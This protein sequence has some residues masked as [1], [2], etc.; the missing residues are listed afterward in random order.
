MSLIQ[1][2]LSPIV[3]LREREGATALSMFVFSFCM[4]ASYNAIKPV[5]RSAF[6]K[7]LGADNLPWMPLV[8]A[9]VIAFLMGGYSWMFQ[10]LPRRWNLPIVQTGMAGL[11]VLFWFLFQTQAVWVAVAFY[12]WGLLM[13][14]LLISQFWTLANIIY[15]P[16]Q[17]KRLFGFIGGGAPLGGFAGALLAREATKL[18]TYNLLFYSAA[19]LMAAVLAVS[20]ILQREKPADTGG[21]K[22]VEGE[23]GVGAGEALR[24]LR[25][26]KHLQVISLVIMFA[27]IGAQV[28]E[29]QLNMA[30]ESSKGRTDID[31]IT[32]FLATIGVWMSA[33]A[34]VIQVWLTSRIH[35]LLGI[36]FALM[37]L[38]VSLGA[39]ALVMLFNAA[40]W[41]P[42]LARVL[43][44]SLR[45]TIDKTTREIL[46]LPLPNE[47]KLRAKPFVDVT[48]DRVGKG[49]AGLLLLVMVQP[50]GLN[51]D[52]QRVS[53]ASLIMV[54][55]WVVAALRAK[56]GYLAAF[57]RSIERRDV[58]VAEVRIST[59]DLGTVETLVEELAHPDETRVLYAIDVLESLD[60]RNLVTPLLL[61]HESSAVRARALNALAVARTEIAARWLPAVERMLHDG[62]AGVRAAAVW[63]L[64]TIRGE[65]AVALARP[66]LEDRDPRIACT[67]AVVLA[68]SARGEDRATAEGALVRIAGDTRAETAGA[69]RDMAAA[70]GRLPHAELRPLLIYDPDPSVA[71]EAL[72]TVKML[73]ASDF[74]FVP[75]LVSLLRKRRLKSAA[76]EVLVSYGEPVLD[77]LNHFLRDSEEEIWVR[78]HLPATLAQFETQRAVDILTGA[79]QEPD[80]FLRYKAVAGLERL[81]RARPDLT[82]PREPI[83]ALALREGGRFLTYL[84]LDDNL[85]RAGVAKDSLLAHALAEK[86]RRTSD[87]V[88][89]LLALIYPWKDIA[90]A[91]WALERGD[92]RAKSSASE[93]LDNILTGNLRKRLMPVLED[94]PHD[95][96]VRKAHVQLRS[97][98]RDVEETL[99]EL[100]NDED[101]VVSGAAIDL[102]REIKLWALEDDIEHVLAHRDVK[103]W[104]VFEAASWTLAAKRVGEARRRDLW[105][106]PLPA[107][108]IASRLTRLPLFASLWVD[109]LF[110]IAS[111]GRQ[112]RNEGG[113]VLLQEG[114]TPEAVHVLL[115]GTCVARSSTGEHARQ[116]EA[117]ATLGFEEALAGRPM[118]ETVRCSGQCVTLSAPADTVEALL[119]D[120]TD[121][122]EGLFRTLLEA[123]PIAAADARAVIKGAAPE[124]LQALAQHGLAPVEK[125]LV[126]KAV[127]VFARVS[128]EELL[129]IAA[130]ARETRL[131]AGTTLGAEGDAAAIVAVITGELSVEPA[132]Q[133]PRDPGPRSQILTAGPG[134]LVG[135]Y[136]TMAGL[137][138]GR[139]I[140]VTRS[141]SALRIERS[142]LFDLAGQRPALLQQMFSALFRTEEPVASAPDQRPTS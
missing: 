74:L 120:N 75:T 115:D 44:Q 36:G 17:A 116:I 134:D 5:T 18:G 109:E 20:F 73:G 8:T 94:L 3:E 51:L 105:L 43:D 42:G 110:R 130:I 28:I 91:R 70:L 89:R 88:Y 72:H 119:A 128:A 13:G 38:P 62:D 64:A 106:E 101:Q 138:F 108:E 107:V 63:A 7:D 46:F 81:R 104:Y 16:R 47:L 142:D 2:L 126:L 30:A 127:P 93:Y 26:S 49:I 100:I 41:A 77:V 98:P 35:R 39:T 122:V 87:R 14:I 61:Y 92:A 37:I 71:E 29:Q 133:D 31:A 52:W 96:R 86:V 15:D 121:L 136:S 97:R 25:E 82:F 103:D 56:R 78:R 40:L 85:R 76:R 67:A 59:A 80:G 111:A 132:P 83:E 45:Y 48:V 79:L 137:P 95:E 140:H 33:I 60:K 54:G 113:R 114:S 34:F 27:A 53:Y 9:V 99:L 19:I 22:A 131:E 102:V 6:I 129:Q 125:A 84:T 21:D 12:L 123:A 55:L 112:T 139:T 10:R 23:K 11:L 90:A 135:V 68:G 50:W 141:G 118:T 65:D 32:S 117:P 1:R 69:R 66:L 24:L 58:E 57:R 124:D 4:M